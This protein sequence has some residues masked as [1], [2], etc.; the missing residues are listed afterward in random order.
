MSTVFSLICFDPSFQKMAHYFL[1]H[2]SLRPTNLEKN[3]KPCCTSTQSC[4]SLCWWYMQ[5][6]CKLKGTCHLALVETLES[7]STFN[8]LLAVVICWWPLQTVWTHTSLDK[9]N[10]H[11]KIV[12]ITLPISFSIYFGCS[13]EPSH[14]DGS[15]EHP[16]HMFWLR[17]KKIIF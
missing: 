5:S 9:H 10:L 14:W 7:S 8:S 13:K 3:L 16:Q 1:L 11:S 17:N 15:F 4:Q 12:N 6:I 2:G